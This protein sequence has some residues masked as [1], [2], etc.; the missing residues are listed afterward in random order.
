MCHLQAPGLIISQYIVL[1][2]CGYPEVHIGSV[3]TMWAL[4]CWCVDT[5]RYTLALCA[6]C[7]QSVWMFSY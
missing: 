7:G 6:K 4:Y 2:V 5:S 1:S 3:C